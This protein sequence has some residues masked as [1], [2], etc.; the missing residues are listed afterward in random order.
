MELLKRPDNFLYKRN[1][2]GNGEIS[3]RILLL[4]V[5]DEALERCGVPW[6]DGKRFLEVLSR[7]A[8]LQP[9]VVGIDVIFEKP[10]SVHEAKRFAEFF[11]SNKNFIIATDLK[12]QA[13]LIEPLQDS[14]ISIGYVH[15]GH[16]YDNWLGIVAQVI[17]LFRLPEIPL[18]VELAGRASGLQFSS[19]YEKRKW[20]ESF[21]TGDPSFYKIMSQPIPINF[22]GRLNDFNRI[23][24]CGGVQDLGV[25]DEKDK[26][27]LIVGTAQHFG[28]YH[29]SPLTPGAKDTPGAIILANAV[30][31]I[32]AGIDMRVITFTE[33]IVILFLFRIALGWLS[34]KQPLRIQIVVGVAVICC[35]I[36]LS[37]LAF[38]YLRFYFPIVPFCLIAVIGGLWE[39]ALVVREQSYR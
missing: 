16:W 28:D 21:R 6:E 27:V 35:V 23:S 30:N 7:I 25:E 1:F 15:T 37:L 32:V 17:N 38:K 33:L 18:A 13:G 20:V 8:D 26:I 4:D 14:R 22:A 31:T 5:D 12:S 19:E 24:Y 29:R 9:T 2:P 36:G 10:R 39:R 11:E 3:D 34:D